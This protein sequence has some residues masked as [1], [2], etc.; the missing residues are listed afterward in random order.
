[1]FSD[2]GLS[3]P[4]IFIS[5]SITL[6]SLVSICLSPFVFRH[7]YLKK[8][9][10]ARDLYLILSSQDFIS[11]IVLSANFVT[12]VVG[13]KEAQ[14][15]IS[16]NTTFC[17]KNYFEYERVATL[18]EKLIGCWVWFLSTTPMCTTCVLAVCRWYQIS[19]PFRFLRRWVVGVV[20]AVFWLFLAITLHINL[21]GDTPENPTL[22]VI[23]I[24]TAWNYNPR[25][26]MKI[27]HYQ[28][29]DILVI[30]LTS[31]AILASILTA[32]KILQSQVF[33]E[34][35]ERR[36]KKIKSTIKIGLLNLGNCAIIGVLAS[37]SVVTKNTPSQFGILQMTFC[38]LPILQSSFN[39]LVYILMT[40][41]VFKPS[42]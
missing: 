22:M 28:L 32:R 41:D 21:I 8:Q 10:T 23:P 19:F 6:V 14:C 11:S 4:D 25:L 12:G 1:M 20:V 35:E 5:A 34:D 40:K 31:I 9:S 18:S 3:S 37:F 33:Q 29:E 30:L 39:P 17:E 38:I 26:L 24:Q 15:M 7:N 16:H 2:G 42:S 27:A 13:P 36:K